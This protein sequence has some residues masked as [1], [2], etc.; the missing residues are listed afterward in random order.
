MSDTGAF[1]WNTLKY[2]FLFLLTVYFKQ[3]YFYGKTKEA[4]KNKNLWFVFL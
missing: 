4:M 2:V 3:H 1:P